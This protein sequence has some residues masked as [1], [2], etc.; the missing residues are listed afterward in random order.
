MGGKIEGQYFDT[1]QGKEIFSFSKEPRQ[2][3]GF[4]QP[5]TVNL[6]RAIKTLYYPTDAQMYNS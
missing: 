6:P 2:E 1:R 3:I 4:T 5:P